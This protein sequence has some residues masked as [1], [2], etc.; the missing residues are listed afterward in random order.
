MAHGHAQSRL[1]LRA[2]LRQRGRHPHRSLGYGCAAADARGVL[3]RAAIATAAIF[4]QSTRPITAPVNPAT[5]AAAAA[6]LVVDAAAAL[7]Y[8]PR[9]GR[10]LDRR[11]P[12][13]VDARRGRRVGSPD[14]WCR[15]GPCPSQ[16][17]RHHR[18][19]RSCRERLQQLHSGRVYG[20]GVRR[21]GHQLRHPV[22]PYGHL[23]RR[24]LHALQRLHWVWNS[25]HMF[26]SPDWPHEHR[27]QAAFGAV[28]HRRDG[29]WHH[30]SPG[31]Q[32][33]HHHRQVLAL[34]QP[35]L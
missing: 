7:V 4:H 28:Y 35:H 22:L 17:R 5:L 24:A 25:L 2:V 26:R 21:Y 19:Q 18:K 20:L 1:G 15:L 32:L 13:G 34:G 9:A 29:V 16:P 27:L 31:L 8:H 11:Q 23:C 6:A 10:L 3:R 14:G 33:R 30:L 12:R